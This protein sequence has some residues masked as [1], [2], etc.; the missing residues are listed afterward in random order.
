MQSLQVS[1]TALEYNLLLKKQRSYFTV[2]YCVAT[3]FQ[4]LVPTRQMRGARKT[5]MSHKWND[6]KK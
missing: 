2:L 4:L 1:K 5:L 6:Y 3:D